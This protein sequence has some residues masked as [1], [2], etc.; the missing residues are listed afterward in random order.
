MAFCRKCGSEIPVGTKFCEKCGENYYYDSGHSDASTGT[1]NESKPDHHKYGK[2]L[3]IILFILSIIDFMTDPAILTI[4]LSVLIIAGAIFCFSQKYKLKFFTVMSIILATICLLSG[5]SQ[6]KRIGLFN[7]PGTNK[8]I[9][10]DI[11]DFDDLYDDVYD[12]LDDDIDDDI[13]DVLSQNDTIDEKSYEDENENS[14]TYA[15]TP[16]NTSEDTDTEVDDETV[17]ESSNDTESVTEETDDT[18]TV[19]PELKAFLDS[20]EAFID[21]YVSF[22]IKY[23]E[24]PDNALEMLSEYTAI[25]SKYSDFAE[26]VSQ[27]DAQK[28]TLSHEDAKYYLEVINRCN[29]KMLDIY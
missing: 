18:E 2:Y 28:D 9:E 14:D 26:K 23:Q 6:A 8:V 11:D 1:V 16:D 27:Y 24:N 17:N 29:E 7:I 4:V 25:M 15:E 20:Y 12:D 5:I 19:D 13:K 22:M 21:E 10:E 3:G